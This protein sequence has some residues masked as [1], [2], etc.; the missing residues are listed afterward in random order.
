MPSLYETGGHRKYLTADERARFLKTTETFPREVRT[1]CGVLA[2]SGC[3][4]S[5][6]LQLT[7]D[8][9]DLAGGA[10]IFESLKK[11]RRGVYRAVPVPP[12]LLDALDLVHGI[13]ETQARKD[14]GRSTRLW[15]WSRATASRRV[16]EVMD[17]AG[18][19]DPANASPKGLR[20]AFGVQAVSRGI[21]LNLVQRWLG[22]AQ[23]TTTAIYAEAVG[24]EERHIASRMWQ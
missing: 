24:E 1:F 3:R 22:H 8:R 9:V 18:L 23:V 17:A 7:A 14:G 19:T 10:L 16:K 12:A 4:I 13:R 6:A 2:Y 5:E 15:T 20:H 11:R 21:A